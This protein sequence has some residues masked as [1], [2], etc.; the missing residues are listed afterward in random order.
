MHLKSAKR[1]PR[2]AARALVALAALAV[3]VFSPVLAGGRVFYER[4]IHLWFWGQAET[5]VRCVAAGSWPVWDPYLAFGHPLWANPGAQVLYPLTWLNLLVQP[6]RFY[7][8]YVV[9]HWLFAGLG[10]YL[11]G[12][13]IGLGFG[14]ALAAAAFWTVSGP[15]LSFTSLWQHYAGLAW[16]PW[17]L[18]AGERAWSEPSARRSLAWGAAAAGQALTGSADM[19]LMTAVVCAAWLLPR[20]RPHDGPPRGRRLAAA[21]GAL[22]W[23]AAFGA[24][25]WVPAL[26]LLA[27]VRR[28]AISPAAIAEWSLHPAS[29]GQLLLPLRPQQLPLRP[30]LGQ[31]LF[32][33][34]GEPLLASLYLGLSLVPLVIL[35]FTGSERRSALILALIGGGA[36]L[37][38]LGHHTPLLVA[39]LHIPPLR[40]LRYPSKALGPASFAWALL[41]GLGLEAWRGGDRSRR[42]PA[43]LAAGGAAL[44]AAALGALALLRPD[45]VERSLLAADADVRPTLLRAAGS[46]LFAALLAGTAAALAAGRARAA[47]IAAAAVAVLDLVVA[48]RGVNPTAP[49][50][51]ARAPATLGAIER[52]PATRVF[53]F[54][55]EVQRAAPPLKRPPLPN[56]FAVAAGAPDAAVARAF[57]LQSYLHSSVA[58]RWGL[59][60]GYEADAL[61]IGTRELLDLDMLL[62]DAEE[63]PGLRRLLQLGAVDYVVALH[64]EGLEDLDLVGVFPSP[65]ARPIHVYRVPDP[66]P[67]VFAVGAARALDDPAGAAALMDPGFDPRREVILSEGQTLTGCCAESRLV[68]YAP[69][70]IRADVETAAPAHLVVVDAWAPGWRATVDGSP[71][72]VMRANLGFRA[73]PVPPGRH[74][75]ELRYR[76]A[77]IRYGL[78]VSAAA[79]LAAVAVVAGASRRG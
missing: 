61:G 22:L 42:T 43:V 53:A 65:F 79:I 44:V 50:A 36:V 17:V 69:D 66:L 75:V 51:L 19:C 46:L 11:F 78:A 70:R 52:G 33:G 56:P 40:M 68:E 30:D 57:G 16:L 24:A 12:R 73:V 71:A 32:D 23:A 9:S 76:P 18:L 2:P 67:R 39:L 27:R 45:A 13:R 55:Y 5:F 4:D 7:T 77:S 48:Q 64:R 6:P 28:A 54:S 47:P 58:S 59:G 3:V 72:P 29:L 35:A 8:L 21:S 74:R 10:T 1:G 60:T 49:A 25:S 63:T 34:R 15:F 62:L 20:A 31:A 14:A 37:V 41:A 26:E 38:A